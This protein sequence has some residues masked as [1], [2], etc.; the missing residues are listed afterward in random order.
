MRLG[1]NVKTMRSKSNDS[2]MGQRG[3][4]RRIGWDGSFTCLPCPDHLGT[5]HKCTLLTYLQIPLGIEEPEKLDKFSHE[6][7]PTGL[8]ACSKPR[9]IIAVEVFVEEYV[10]T[11][12][13]IALELMR[14]SVDGSPTLV[15]AREDPCESVGDLLAHFKE[16]HHLPGPR[17]TLN[18]EVVAVVKIE[19]QERP[20]D[21]SVNRHPDRS[22]PV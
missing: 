5:L 3:S 18:F 4:I 6:P 15:T 10:V 19:V 22:P 13:G 12:V 20:D 2:T 21:E 1:K 17:W 9:T 16:V 14:P 8:V 7:G 11:P